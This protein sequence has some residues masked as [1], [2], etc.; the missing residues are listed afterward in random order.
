MLPPEEVSINTVN[1]ES[2][3]SAVTT[4]NQGERI[5]LLFRK[6]FF[7]RIFKYSSSSEPNG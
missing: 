6:K 3:P 2:D 1:S 7:S 5:P 4:R